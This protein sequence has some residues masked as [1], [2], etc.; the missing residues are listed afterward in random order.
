[1]PIGTLSFPSLGRTLCFPIPVRARNHSQS[2]HS[3]AGVSTRFLLPTTSTHAIIWYITYRLSVLD[4]D[5]SPI[6]LPYSCALRPISGV[7]GGSTW[8]FLRICGL[9]LTCGLKEL[10]FFACCSW[11]N[12]VAAAPDVHSDD[13]TRQPPVKCRSA[14]CDTNFWVFLAGMGLLASSLLAGIDACSASLPPPLE[15]SSI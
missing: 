2:S 14:N 5:P 7:C 8:G 3:P 15:D 11:A 1:Y 12:D 13:F 10:R 9:T 6:S 4:R